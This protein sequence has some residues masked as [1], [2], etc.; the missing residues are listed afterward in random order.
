M[1]SKLY[2]GKYVL[3]QVGLGSSEG[4]KGIDITPQTNEVNFFE[5][6]LSPSVTGYVS[7]VDNFN[8]ISGVN[9]SLPIM[10]NEVI[11]IEIELPPYYIQKDDGSWTQEIPNVIHFI[12]RVTD[13]KNKILQSSDKTL[14]YDIHFA[15]DEL[16]MDRSMRISKSFPQSKYSDVVSNILSGMNTPSIVEVEP[17]L[18]TFNTVIPNWNPFRAINWAA[19]RSISQ[20][21]NTSCFFFWQT[22]Y[23]DD[24]LPASGINTKYYFWS[25]D[26]MIDIWEGDVRK[27]VFFR[28]TGTQAQIAKRQDP[29]SY[30]SFSTALNYQVVH[31]FDTLENLD[32]G[33]FNSTLITHDITKKKYEKYI[34]NY[35]TEFPKYRHL[36]SGKIFTGVSDDNNKVFTDYTNS[37]I[38]MS[39][40]G[41][42]ESPNLLQYV[43]QSRIN[44][45][46]SLNT[47]KLN[48]T[49]P[50]DGLIQ[51]GDLINFRLPS[52]ETGQAQNRY[53]EFYEG[54][55]IVSA[56]RH[57]FSRH[58]AEYRMH[59]ECSK[60]SL[61]NEVRG[62][63][64]KNG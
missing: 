47:F 38:L 43:T 44:R 12:G 63:T 14:A 30:M 11:Y 26:K 46:Q 50:G 4:R 51:S 7:V 25:L 36:D 40:A 49:I 21:Y 62:Y 6:I 35:E 29:G 2:P 18:N 24:P 23:S 48:L 64:P 41:T 60:E 37:R 13:I 10:G 9:Y 42:S 34:Y 56:I 53:D 15:T 5:S 54:K 16:V 1:T 27:T 3:R 32:L 58:G 28:P 45:M 31:S 61:K 19:A 57:S 22:L 17:T 52:P 20:Q 33:F 55:Y 59:M 39:S 8:Y